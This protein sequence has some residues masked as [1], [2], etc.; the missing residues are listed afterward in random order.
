[1]SKSPQIRFYDDASSLRR[2]VILMVHGVNV[3]VP[4]STV[5]EFASSYAVTRGTPLEA[6]D[7]IIWVPESDDTDLRHVRTFPAHVCRLTTEGRSML[8]VEVFWGDISHVPATL[9]GTIAG[10]FQIIFSLRFAAKYAAQ[11]DGTPT[12]LQRVCGFI[13]WLIHGPVLAIN[14]FLAIAATAA[15][16][17]IT[18]VVSTAN[19]ES[20]LHGTTL[21]ATAVKKVDGIVPPAGPWTNPTMLA[22]SVLI[23]AVCFARTVRDTK[24]KQDWQ[25]VDWTMIAL[26]TAL[27]AIAA[28][29]MYADDLSGES[30]RTFQFYGQIIINVLNAVWGIIAL[31]LFVA[32][33]VMCASVLTG[34]RQARSGYIA[35][36]I[37]TSTIASLWGLVIPTIWINVLNRI[38]IAFR[39]Q[40]VELLL[41]RALTLLGYLWLTAAIFVILGAGTWIHLQAWA[42]RNTA[43]GCPPSG[44]NQAP[45]LILSAVM[46]TFIICST[47]MWSIAAINEGLGAVRDLAM[48]DA[49]AQ[50][51]QQHFGLI[52][53]AVTRLNGFAIALIGA[54]GI[55]LTFYVTHLRLVLDIVLDVANHF[56]EE[57]WEEPSSTAGEP[58][59]LRY[60]RRIRD[61]IRARMRA[62][63]NAIDQQ[64]CQDAE[65]IVLS[66][67]Q[68]TIVAADVLGEAATTELLKP[69]RRRAWM[70][71]GSPLTHLYNYYFSGEYPPLDYQT[72]RWQRLDQNMEQWINVYRID[73]FVGTFVTNSS[74]KKPLNIPVDRGGHTGYWSDRQVLAR[75]E[76][77]LTEQGVG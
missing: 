31:S 61:R 12:L 26:G 57:W 48:S 55:C 62:V 39:I 20:Q 6:V 4:G 8:M 14:L 50:V 32:F 35:A 59:T 46:T 56:R 76:Q 41:Q 11:P 44:R 67:S 42:A 15:L 53:V 70:T 2:Q 63:L 28:F 1:M 60:G 25:S 54:V 68:G 47:V 30:T 65:L 13:A 58:P 73:D 45:R 77:C 43:A 21:T 72:P 64:S 19:L 51:Q 33:V 38:P 9:W 34:S 49:H 75:I 52:P 71:F 10:L 22:V 37:F 16:L 27:A 29:G 69:F 74:E 23:V 36:F 7:E 66:H 40:G 5:Q 24:A 3:D 17:T 18:A